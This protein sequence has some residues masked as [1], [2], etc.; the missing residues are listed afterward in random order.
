MHK[1]QKDSLA[2]KIHVE[3]TEASTWEA[4]LTDEQNLKS[5]SDTI[6]GLCNAIKRAPLQGKPL[7]LSH[8]GRTSKRSPGMLNPLTFDDRLL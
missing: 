1:L 7:F 8:K 6:F 5:V 4:L 2:L 3:I